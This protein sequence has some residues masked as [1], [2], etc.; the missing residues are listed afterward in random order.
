MSNKTYTVNINNLKISGPP[1]DLRRLAHVYSLAAYTYDDRI[2]AEI[3]NENSDDTLIKE[4]EIK[5]KEFENI[6]KQ[7]INTIK[8][9]D[10]YKKYK[11]EMSYLIT[12]ILKEIKHQK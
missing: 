7:I 2:F 5:K 12:K 9:S 10:Y 6:E 1:E 8:N 3:Y 11:S 4:L